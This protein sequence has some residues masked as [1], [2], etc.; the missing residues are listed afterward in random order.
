MTARAWFDLGCSHSSQGQYETA[1]ESLR[2]ALVLIPS[3]LGAQFELGRALCSLGELPEAEL[4]FEGLVH[5]DPGN[6]SAYFYLGYVNY[7]LN[8]VA[9]AI[10]IW[11]CAS[12][13]LDEPSDCLENLAMAYRR[14]GDLEK[15]KSCWLRL[16]ASAPEHPAAAHMLSAHGQTEL[17][18]R[19][20]DGYL[21]HIFDRF[22]Q[23]FDRVL[24]ALNYSVPMYLDQLLTE[25][26]DVPSRSLKILDA[27]CG[28]GLCGQHLRPWASLLTGV[29]ISAG[30]LEKAKEREIYHE[31]HLSELMS[32]L[33]NTQEEYDL[34]A[35]S[36][37]F[38]YFGNI[39]DLVS[40]TKRRL[41]PGGRLFFSVECYSDASDESRGYRIQSHGRYCHSAGHVEAAARFSTLQI[42]RMS[43]DTIRYESSQPVTGLLVVLRKY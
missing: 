32:F 24:G 3:N 43:L 27:G 5:Q 18:E 15:E 34:I 29:D 10:K 17:S 14:V 39:I 2:C 41:I 9:R 30:M 20:D 28:T 25:L 37:V 19:A 16:R 21:R 38:C 36:D 13:L 1:V 26:H 12:R 6:G 40:A 42:E 33:T 11:E 7:N 23:D 8:S 31:L 4:L 35:A 22:A